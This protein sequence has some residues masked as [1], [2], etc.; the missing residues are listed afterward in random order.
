MDS[1]N[2]LFSTL[3]QITKKDVQ[4]VSKK[5]KQEQK[6]LKSLRM[7]NNRVKRLIQ[8]EL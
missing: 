6:A 2:V 1:E 3:A 8:F 4:D 7:K 5:Y